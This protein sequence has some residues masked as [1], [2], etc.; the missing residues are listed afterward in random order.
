MHA[1]MQTYMYTSLI[2]CSGKYWRTAKQ[3][4]KAIGESKFGDL[5][6]Q[7]LPIRVRDIL[8]CA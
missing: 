2:P 7:A 8:I 4:S 1:C 6:V 5:Q 3:L